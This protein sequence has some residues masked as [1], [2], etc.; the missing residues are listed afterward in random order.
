MADTHKFIDLGRPRRIWAVGA[1]HADVERLHRLHNAIGRQFQ[2][3]DRIVYLG[4]LIGWG[5]NVL[6]TIDELL[7]FRR[8][9]IAV[10]GA[11]AGDVVYL[12]GAQEEMWNK[13][14]QL[15]FAPNPR[16][17]LDWMLHQGVAS[18]L[19]AYGG[20]PDQGIVAA[21]NGAMMLGRWTK[22][23]RAA[24]LARP[25]HE[26]LF[27]ALRRAAFTGT[28]GTPEAGGILL[29]SAGVDPGRPFGHQTDSFWWGA[30]GFSRIDQPFSGF[31]RVVRGYDPARQGI[32]VTDYT[33]TFDAGCGF[34][35]PLACGCLSP[36]GE[37]HDILQV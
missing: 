16:E 6:D 21:R 26:N 31:H 11:L 12:R 4:N 7:V 28:P 19:A 20:S 35:G 25:G 30:P 34:G 37:I 22:G 17:V 29:V 24:M 10:P 32:A 5:T 8:A 27:S 1:I 23:L 2:P 13:L 18:T 3:G 14:L 36:L 15:H 33:A 9:V